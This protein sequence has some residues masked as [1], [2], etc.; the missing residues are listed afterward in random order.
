MD[1]LGGRPTSASRIIGIAAECSPRNPTSTS[2][3]RTVGLMSNPII[4]HFPI[5]K[6]QIDIS[7]PTAK[8]TRIDTHVKSSQ[9]LV[10]ISVTDY[11]ANEAGRPFPAI[12]DTGCTDSL[13]ILEEQLRNWADVA[14]NGLVNITPRKK[15]PFVVRGCPAIRLQANVWIHFATSGDGWR[16]PQGN[17]IACHV[18]NGIVALTPRSSKSGEDAAN[19]PRLPLVGL[20]AFFTRDWALLIRPKRRVFDL[21]EHPS[22]DARPA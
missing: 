7:F 6:K 11:I 16:P 15:E 4:E 17:S 2:S 12:F 14:P 5:P 21:L 9:M 3:L 1:R 13:V 10:W 8:Q 22:D 18:P 19:A 20:P